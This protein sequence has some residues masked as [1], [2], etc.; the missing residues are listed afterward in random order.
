MGDCPTTEQATS[1]ISLYADDCGLWTTNTTWQKTVDE[2]QKEIYRLT[3]WAKKKRIKFEPTKTVALACHPREQTR[4]KMKMRQL[5]L[6]RDKSEPIQWEHKGRFLGVIFAE[7][8]TFNE[9]IR[10]VT[11]RAVNRIKRMYRFQG[12]VKGETMYKVYKT[13]IEPIMLYGTEVLYEN[14]TEINLKKFLA[15]EMFAIKVSYTM[16]KH[17]SITKCLKFIENS[18]VTNIDKRRKN[19]IKRN[20]ESEIIRHTETTKYSQGRRLRVRQTHRDRGSRKEG[21]KAK[22]QEHKKVIFFSDIDNDNVQE[23]VE[24]TA[25]ENKDGKTAEQGKR[26]T[27]KIE[28]NKTKEGKETDKQT[29]RSIKTRVRRGKKKYATNKQGNLIWVLEGEVPWIELNFDPG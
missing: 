25:E 24:G 3:D 19:F 16:K 7:N 17:E 11:Q 29:T 12:K 27:K 14:L 21:W 1:D 5:Y 23:I 4:R 13:A 22:L 20:Y 9:H 18:I 8:C 15:V 10:D 2:I 28:G 26:K 6:N